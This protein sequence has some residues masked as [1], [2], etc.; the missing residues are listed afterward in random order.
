[1]KKF[2]YMV[3]T[4]VTPDELNVYGDVGWRL[5][6]IIV[7][8]WGNVFYFMREIDDAPWEERMK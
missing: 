2:E 3:H 4:G 6:Q 1:M 8:E 7:H 5:I